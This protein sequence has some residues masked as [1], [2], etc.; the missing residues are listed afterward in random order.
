[1]VQQNEL[2]WLLENDVWDL[3]SST[4]NSSAV[5]FGSRLQPCQTDWSDINSFGRHLL[6]AYCGLVPYFL[7][8]EN[9]FDVGIVF[10]EVFK[11]IFWRR[12]W[13]ELWKASDDDDDANGAARPPLRSRG[14]SPLCWWW[15]RFQRSGHGHAGLG[16]RNG[17][18]STANTQLP[19]MRSVDMWVLV[20]ATDCVPVSCPNIFRILTRSRRR[21]RVVVGPHLV[22]T[23]RPVPRRCSV[24]GIMVN[25]SAP[26]F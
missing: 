16:G 22:P 23:P 12:N 21:P 26:C 11:K 15:R 1:M 10:V 25:G 3:G 2:Q 8:C 4:R 7:F 6:T 13:A 18:L 14:W 9:I 19:R 20:S 17:W 24:G 5:H